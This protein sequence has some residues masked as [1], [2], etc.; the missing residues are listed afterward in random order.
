MKKQGTKWEPNTGREVEKD[1][2]KTR[3]KCLENRLNM[4]IKSEKYDDNET[5]EK[6]KLLLE[7]RRKGNGDRG[8]NRC[9]KTVC[10]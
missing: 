5:K 6:E 2:R 10:G 9:D 4:R 3:H 8:T 7:K 1:E